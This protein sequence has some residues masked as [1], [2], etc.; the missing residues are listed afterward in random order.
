[1]KVSEIQQAEVK[2]IKMMQER[3]YSKEIRELV[4]SD[5]DKNSAVSLRRLNPFVDNEGVL[6]VGGRLANALEDESFKCPVV[7]PKKAASTKVMIQ[8]HHAQIEHRGKHST[9]I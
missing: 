5:Q 1:M 7:M 2:I 6:R 4:E 8:W 9:K 3:A